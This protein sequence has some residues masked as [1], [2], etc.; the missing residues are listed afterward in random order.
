MSSQKLVTDS[1]VITAT[2]T[3]V[4]YNCLSDGAR[5]LL[6]FIWAL[7]IRS[8]YGAAALTNIRLKAIPVTWIPFIICQARQE[9]KTKI[10]ATHCAR[11]YIN[12]ETLIEERNEDNDCHRSVEQAGFYDN[13]P[14]D[15][16]PVSLRY[17]PG[18]TYTGGS[19]S[20]LDSPYPPQDQP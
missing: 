1:F 12:S 7:S 6:R 19:P 15:L 11:C 13:T 20:L 8:W 5:L 18:R 10:E 9:T 3:V 17:I 14:G 16:K 4:R 2:S